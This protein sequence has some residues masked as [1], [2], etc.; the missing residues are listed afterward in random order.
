MAH[1]DIT[2]VEIPVSGFE[3][4]TRFYSALFGWEIAEVAGFEGYPMWHAPNGISGGAL[5][6]RAHDTDQPRAVVEVDSVDEAVT[7]ALER[8]GEVVTPRT[9]ITEASAWALLRD[10]DGNLIGVIEG[11]TEPSD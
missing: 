6:P 5:I 4:A 2:H 11:M 10:P 1:G 8:G 7:R 3:D 9:P